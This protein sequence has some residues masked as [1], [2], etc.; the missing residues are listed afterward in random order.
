MSV[1]EPELAIQR[2][3]AD[4]A[5]PKNAFESLSKILYDERWRE[6]R[7]I[8]FENYVARVFQHLGYQVEETPTTGDQGVDLIVILGNRRTDVQI[9]GYYHSVSNSAIQEVVG[10]MKFHRCS[11][12]CVVTNSKFTKSAIELAVANSCRC[13][14]DDNF[15]D[16]VYGRIFGRI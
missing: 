13:V 6:L 8:D 12:T 11:Q 16:F 7:G 2:A 4:E 3:Q 9:K 15:Q 10:G 14:S 5:R 1:L